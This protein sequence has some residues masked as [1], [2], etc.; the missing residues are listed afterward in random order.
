M[1]QKNYTHITLLV[2][3]SGSMTGLKHDA[4]GGINTFFEEQKKVTGKC[5]YSIYQFDTTFESVASGKNIQ[6]FETY[7]LIP[8]GGTALYDAQWR[9]IHETGAFLRKLPEDQRPDKVIFITV[10]DGEE[11]SSREITG[12]HGL[13]KLK[14]LVREQED[15]YAWEFIY[16]GA[17]QDAFA[18]GQSFGV[19]RTMTYAGTGASTAGTYANLSYTVSSAR[20]TG[21]DTS[22]FMASNIDADGNAIYDKTT[23]TGSANSFTVQPAKTNTDEEED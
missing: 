4:D 22:A 20:T 9:A 11:N 15:K 16:I 5:T 10:T 12:L 21:L 23:T 17:N 1:T 6:E 18:V 3:R 8:A 2:D 7:H 19:G 13:N 14:N